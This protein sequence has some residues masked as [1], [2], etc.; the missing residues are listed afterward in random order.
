VSTDIETENMQ[1][2]IKEKIVVY[3]RMIKFSHTIFA[4]PFA[5]SAVALA[6]RLHPP[7]PAQLL[8]I[9]LA[10]VGARSAAMG[11]NRI[12]DADIDSRNQRTAIREIPSGVLSKKQAGLFVGLSSALF[13]FCAWMLSDLC[14]YLS[15]PVLFFL[16]FYSFTKRFTQ[17]CH[18]YLGAAIGLAPAGAWVALTGTFSLGAILLSLALMTYIAGFDILYACQDTEFD[19]EQALY[20]LPSRMGVKKAMA[21]SSVLHLLTLVLLVAM[22]FI[23]AMH[24]VFIIFLAMIAI[25][26][27]VEHRLV[28]PDD[29]SRVHI[30]FFHMNSIISVL[31]FA[32]VVIQGFFT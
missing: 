9:L 3:G 13:V 12:V 30:A 11:F 17:Y 6:W 7:S 14:F 20:S 31:L 32:G 21:V 5:L 16:L 4:L 10:M 24:P 19:R 15:F 8:W 1:W 28:K 18:L 29:L 22:Y 27:I 25:L 26:L 2:S 23:F